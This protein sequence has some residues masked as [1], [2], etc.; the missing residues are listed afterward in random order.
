MSNEDQHLLL[1]CTLH[2][3]S[4]SGGEYSLYHLLEEE[5]RDVVGYE[6]FT[7][8][9]PASH[10]YH[11]IDTANSQSLHCIVRPLVDEKLIDAKAEFVKMEAAG[12]IHHYNSL[13][14]S[15]LHKIC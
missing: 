9:A 3:F 7:N 1:P 13:W 6:E 12:V 5:L 4:T 14:S 10:V 11:S 8:L 15:P 2:F